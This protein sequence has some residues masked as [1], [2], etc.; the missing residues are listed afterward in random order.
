MGKGHMIFKEPEM[1]AEG[2]LFS[3]NVAVVERDL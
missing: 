1:N 2:F 3:A